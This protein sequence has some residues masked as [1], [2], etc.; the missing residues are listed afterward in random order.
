M[1]HTVSIPTEAGEFV[2]HFSERGLAALDFPVGKK[3]ESRSG[4]RVEKPSRPQLSTRIPLNTLAVNSE[5]P[6]WEQ[7]TAIALRAA[8]AGEPAGRLPPFDWHCATEFQQSIWRALL[9][10]PTGRT[11]TYAELA[12]AAGHPRAV[13]AAGSACGANPIPVLV[14]CH[15]VVAS[16]G[17]LGGFSSGL[18]WK[19]RLLAREG[20]DLKLLTEI[21]S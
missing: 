6:G 19:R 9:R 7:L 21:G 4:L 11:S 18:D 10:I 2:A 16:A 17:K 13:R 12:A 8:L 1:T 5:F 20:V 3:V 14:P 15:R